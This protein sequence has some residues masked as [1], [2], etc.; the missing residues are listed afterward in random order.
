MSVLTLRYRNL[1][2]RYKLRLIILVTVIAALLPTSAAVVAYDQLAARTE[3]RNDLEVLAEIVG[4]NA[5]AAVTFG[6]RRA[7]MELLSG[8][9]AKKH[10]VTAVIYSEDG[11]PFA[12]YRRDPGPGAAWPARRN[13]GSRFENDRLIVFRDIPLANQNAG[14][15]YLESDLGELEARLA[16]FAWMLFLVPL[17]SAGL[18]LAISSKLQRVVS[19][20]IA[21]L[22]V[23][24]K[25]VSVKKDY[26][27]RALKQSDDDLGQLIETFNG[28]LSEIE[29]RDVALLNRRDVLEHE[30]AA[31]TAELVLAKDRAEAASRAKSEFLAN[32]S[33]EIRTPMNGVMGMTELVLDS[34]LS[35]DQRECLNTV[36]TS[37]IRC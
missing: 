25:R 34:D 17:V 22:A 35:P 11:Q 12:G 37:P 26:T 6:D 3:M 20:P 13:A 10:I 5:T 9:R 24:A 2:V 21:H 30:V 16:R 28:M 36:K 19:E 32:M 23:V 27:V 15:I 29:S 14:F 1:A 33:H 18:A 7:A 8:L 31:R 4:S